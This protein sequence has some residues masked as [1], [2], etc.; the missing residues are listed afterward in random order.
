MS[1]CVCAVCAAAVAAAAVIRPAQNAMTFLLQTRPPNMHVMWDKIVCVAHK[2][3][4]HILYIMWHT[5]SPQRESRAE[6][7]SE[8]SPTPPTDAAGQAQNPSITLPCVRAWRGTHAD[9]FLTVV[10]ACLRR[11]SLVCVCVFACNSHVFTQVHGKQ[12]SS[13]VCAP[14]RR[15]HSETTRGHSSVICQRKPAHLLLIAWG[16]A[17]LR[18]QLTLYF[19]LL[20]LPSFFW[21]VAPAK[22]M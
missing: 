3:P 14:A 15:S 17:T 13:C 19:V 9:L 12:S 20:L 6:C 7:E 2:S 8:D 5:I 22:R 10:R 16:C 21:F 18:R 1:V 11:A 4:Q